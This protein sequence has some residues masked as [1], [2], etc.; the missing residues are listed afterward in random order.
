[1]ICLMSL[2][3]LAGFKKGSA[4]S[5]GKGKES[6]ESSTDSEKKDKKKN[7]D[8]KDKKDKDKDKDKDK[9]K[10]D[11]TDYE[12]IYAPILKEVLD[13]IQNG[14]DYDA[15]YD[16]VLNGLMEEIMYGETDELLESIGYV[17]MDINK[18][19]VPE[20]L[21]GK[22]ESFG[23][24]DDIR[25]NVFNG[26]SCK[27]GKPVCFLD[28]WARSLHEWMGDGHFFYF[29][30]GGAMLSA[31]GE[32]HLGKNVEELE[33]DDF[34]FTD[35]KNNGKLG[36][37]HNTTGYWDVAKAEE[38]KI[39]ED[40][41]WEIMDDYELEPLDWTPIGDYKEGSTKT[42]SVSNPSAV[43]VAWA[44]DVYDKYVKYT[45]YEP[46]DSADYTAHVIF[47][48][49]KKV[50]NFRI[51]EL[52]VKNIDDDGNIEF[53]YEECFRKASLK[54]EKPIYA[55]LNF[56]GDFPNNG[57]MYTDGNGKDRLFVLEE[58]GKDGSLVVWEYK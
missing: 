44:E 32:A 5:S 43:S 11:D 50:K 42:G 46:E 51:V 53:L 48:V 10:T 21:I 15:E 30:S 7:S 54:P 31:F 14:Y 45:K 57:F 22:N 26:Y 40:S 36:F 12:A 55:G 27:D 37:Y 24:N 6:T 56:I 41:F 2:F 19:K 16:Y 3:V 33:W 34:Y 49:D 4:D 29:G 8:K 20:L 13:T 9:K 17:I 23:D 52:S 25:S 28:G 1:M 58:S 18:D 47:S 38:L 35:E 39:S